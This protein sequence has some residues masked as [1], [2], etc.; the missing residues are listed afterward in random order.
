M[1]QQSTAEW[2]QTLRKLGLADTDIT[3]VRPEDVLYLVDRWQFLQVVENGGKCKSY[4]EP[5]IIKLS[6]GWDLIDYGNAMATSPGKFLYGSGYFH[7][8]DDDDGEGGSGVVNPGH[9]TIFKQ[10]FDSA[11]EL[12]R[13]AQA[14]GWEGVLIVDG[15]L[16]DIPAEMKRRRTNEWTTVDIDAIKQKMSDFK[17]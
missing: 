12:I 5:K 4:D 11:A 16:A 9:G 14:Q 3:Q 10:A 13:F 8:S 15:H 17:R 7:S 2:Q 6:S 1:S